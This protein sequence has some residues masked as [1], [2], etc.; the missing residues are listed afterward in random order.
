MKGPKAMAWPWLLAYGVCLSQ[1]GER[2]QYRLLEGRGPASGW[3]SLAVQGKPHL[4]SNRDSRIAFEVDGV[5]V[6]LLSKPFGDQFWG[7]GEW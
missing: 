5:L 6:W 7:I 3:V 2:L 4:R 1:E